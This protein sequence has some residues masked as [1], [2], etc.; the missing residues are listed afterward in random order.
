MFSCCNYSSE[1]FGAI[2]SPKCDPVPRL[3]FA[4]ASRSLNCLAAKPASLLIVPNDN[5][6]GRCYDKSA[7]Q[8]H[9]QLAIAMVS[10][11]KQLV[12]MIG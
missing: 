1:Y 8:E 4:E 7:F 11:S 5:H 3:E 12:L 6:S 2:F 9:D 10:R